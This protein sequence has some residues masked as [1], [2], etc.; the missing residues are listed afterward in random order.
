VLKFALQSEIM[1]RYNTPDTLVET[2]A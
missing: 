1:D 2:G